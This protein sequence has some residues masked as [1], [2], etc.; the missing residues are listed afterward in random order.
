MIPFIELDFDRRKYME[1]KT[2]L[3][4]WFS[5]FTEDIPEKL[6]KYRKEG[7]KMGYHNRGPKWPQKGSLFH[8]TTYWVI[9]WQEGSKANITLK[10]TPQG[11]SV[12]YDY[13][14]SWM[15]GKLM[16]N[17]LGFEEALEFASKYMEKVNQTGEKAPHYS[18]VC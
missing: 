9:Y 1:V 3:K 4:T 2:G 15:G 7:W 14:N 16:E 13:Q 5:Q 6:D 18:V 11:W 12:Y 8:P 10:P 17:E